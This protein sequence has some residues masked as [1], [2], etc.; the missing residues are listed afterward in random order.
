MGYGIFWSFRN[1]R[2][3]EVSRFVKRA[4][5]LREVRLVAFQGGQFTVVADRATAKTYL[6]LN[7]LL[8]SA[9]KHL[10][11]GEP[12]TMVIRE[13]VGEAETRSLLSNPGVQYVRD[14]V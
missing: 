4:S 1:R 11:H 10:F 13:D 6:K 7:A 2:H 3:R 14:D 9:N 12:M 5:S 8:T